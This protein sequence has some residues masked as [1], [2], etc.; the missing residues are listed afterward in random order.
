MQRCKIEIEI[1]SGLDENDIEIKLRQL[2][3]TWSILDP[4]LIAGLI[5][6]IKPME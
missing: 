3:D 1:N 5:I 4:A 6:S 2:L